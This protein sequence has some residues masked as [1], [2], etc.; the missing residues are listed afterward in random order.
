[1]ALK[2][3]TGCF[4]LK[5]NQNS[6]AGAIWTL[7]DYGGGKMSAG[8]FDIGWFGSLA[9]IMTGTVTVIGAV[10]AAYYFRRRREYA[11]RVQFDLGMRII[12]ERPQELLIELTATIR[13]VGF[14]RHQIRSIT[15][16]LRGLR[17]DDPWKESKT[18]NRQISF[19]HEIIPRRSWI[20]DTWETFIEP[21]V[22]QVYP[23]N[24]QIAPDYAYLLLY[25]DMYY[26]QSEDDHVAILTK[27]VA[28]L[29][30]AYLETNKRAT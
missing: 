28:E 26:K 16:S 13:N 24:V 5:Y 8:A 11:P 21:G 1:L 4:N 15:F 10:A 29:R 27:S 9:Q 18:K 17:A 3:A 7:R 14:V 30:A 6:F 25:A 20:P 12:G 2:R 19:K 23:Y 22:T